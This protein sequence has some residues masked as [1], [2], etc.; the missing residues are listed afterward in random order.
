MKW[1]IGE[2]LRGHE[3]HFDIPWGFVDGLDAVTFAIA[4]WPVK[5]AFRGTLVFTLLAEPLLSAF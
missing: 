4:S 1:R 5:A 2:I 3:R